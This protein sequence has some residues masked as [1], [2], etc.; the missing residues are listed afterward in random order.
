MQNVN[1]WSSIR[2][3]LHREGHLKAPRVHVHSSCGQQA[4]QL[5]RTVADMGGEVAQSAGGCTITAAAALN[6]PS[7]TAASHVA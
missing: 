7:P 4:D 5:Q 2:A 3:A 6:R 1:I